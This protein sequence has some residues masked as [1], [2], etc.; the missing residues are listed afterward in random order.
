MSDT[1]DNREPI[2]IQKAIQDGRSRRAASRSR[3]GP[4]AGRSQCA[5]RRARGCA[6]RLPHQSRLRARGAAAPGSRGARSISVALARRQFPRRDRRE[7]VPGA[8]RPGTRGLPGRCV[9]GRRRPHR[10]TLGRSARGRRDRAGAPDQR[11]ERALP[12]RHRLQEAARGAAGALRGSRA[13]CGGVHGRGHHLGR[14][15]RALGGG[16]QDRGVSQRVCGPGARRR[17]RRHPRQRGRVRRSRGR[18]PGRHRH[19][20]CRRLLQH[21]TGAAE[22]PPGGVPRRRG[23]CA[24]TACRCGLVSAAHGAE[25]E[26]RAVR[27][28]GSIDDLHQ[29]GG[30]SCPGRRP[31]GTV[32]FVGDR[33]GGRVRRHGFRARKRD[34]DAA[35][36]GVSDHSQGR[37]R[38]RWR[39]TWSTS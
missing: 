34:C 7:S 4:H 35:R 31:G 29:R 27:V 1:V 2:R 24:G 5:D 28:A 32:R 25:C 26:G 13:N 16:F 22:T 21:R 12:R 6:R 36:Q 20:P 30:V 11:L 18:H 3:A 15:D 10:R 37:G 14:R 17:L 19:Q 39:P 23:G 9:L 38:C 8:G 33:R